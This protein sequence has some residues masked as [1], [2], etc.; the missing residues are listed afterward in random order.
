MLERSYPLDLSVGPVLDFDVEMRDFDSP[1]VKSIYRA[2]TDHGGSFTSVAECY[3]EMVITQQ[4]GQSVL[5]VRG[6]ETVA[7]PSPIPAPA[8]FVGIIFEMGTFM[9]H[10][11]GPTIAD[12]G[13]YLPNASSRTFYLHGDSWEFPT[14]D[15]VDVFVERLI[16][17]ELLVY[18]PVIDTALRDQPQPLSARSIE[19]HFRQVIGLTQGGVRQILR[20]RRANALLRQAVPISDV[21]AEAGYA[22]QPHLTRALK[23][24]VGETPAQILREAILR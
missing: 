9:P 20:A 8:D 6:P 4:Q 19:R 23:H 2:H 17:Q 13:I 7:S 11:P 18:D 1:F 10:M 3:W 15:N 5:I 16:Q 22:D 14:F 24:F 12:T 21:I